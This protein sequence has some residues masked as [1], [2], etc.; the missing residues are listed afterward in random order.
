MKLTTD[1]DH[2]NDTV[3]ICQK[4]RL[5]VMLLLDDGRRFRSMLKNP[6]AAAP[7]SAPLAAHEDTP[8][9]QGPL[10]ARPAKRD[11]LCRDPL[12]L[13]INLRF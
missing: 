6:D 4:L 5:S 12:S 1:N 8:P 2:D 9:Y 10:F 3:R 11:G 7:R 13:E